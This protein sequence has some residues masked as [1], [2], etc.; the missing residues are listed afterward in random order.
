MSMCVASLLPENDT[1]A[2]VSSG[3]SSIL[4]LH[5]ARSG[6]LMI[7]CSLICMTEQSGRPRE[8]GQDKIASK[9]SS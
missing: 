2:Q 8:Y 4:Q 6:N 3:L 7:K 9:D 5:S 1:V